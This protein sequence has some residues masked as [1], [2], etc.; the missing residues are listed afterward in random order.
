MRPFHEYRL[1]VTPTVKTRFQ[2]GRDPTDSSRAGLFRGFIL[3]N[4]DVGAAALTPDVFLFR[5]VGGCDLARKSVLTV[6]PPHLRALIVA[7]LSTGCRVGELLAL[8]WGM[9]RVTGKGSLAR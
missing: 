3:R 1:A 7:A 2:A 9:C 5:A 4:G 6:A 8:Q